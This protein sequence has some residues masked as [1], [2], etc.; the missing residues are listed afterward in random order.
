MPNM[1]RQVRLKW[2]E[3]A[4]PASCAA[5]V[6][7]GP[8][9][10]APIADSTRP[11][12]VGAER[13]ARLRDEQMPEAAGREVRFG[14]RVGQRD[15]AREPA[16][17]PRD[18]ALDARVDALGDGRRAHQQRHGASRLGGQRGVVHAGIEAVAQRGDQALQHPG[19]DRRDGCWGIARHQRAALRGLRLDEDRRHVAAAAVELVTPV[20][21]HDGA[22]ALAPAAA[23]VVVHQEAAAHR[24]RDLDR[25]VRVLLREARLAADP[26]AATVPQDHPANADDGPRGS[27]RTRRR[28]RCVRAGR[29]H[30]GDRLAVSFKLQARRLCRIRSHEPAGFTHPRKDTHGLRLRFCVPMRQLPRHHLC[31][32]LPG[33]GHAHPACRRRGLRVCEPLRLRRGR[34]RLHVLRLDKSRLK[35][36]CLPKDPGPRRDAGARTRPLLAQCSSG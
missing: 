9:M 15:G 30:G 21:H 18:G 28:C 13:H 20:R 24:Q 23:L 34:V 3:S 17:H 5:A 7:D 31:L 4:K 12:Q 8:A 2:A 33:Q 26:Q 14:G 25:M 10:P 29:D 11:Q 19:L 32:R 22:A 6:H 1:R 36:R 16:A 27:E 35:P